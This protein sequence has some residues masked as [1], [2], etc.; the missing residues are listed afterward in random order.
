VG[1]VDHGGDRR[2][3]QDTPTARD[4][5]RN[6]VQIGVV[7]TDLDKTLQA[8]SEIVGIGPWRVVKCPPPGREDDQ[9]YYGERAVFRTRQAFADLGPI[10]LELIQPVE[11]RTIWSDFLQKHGQGIHHIRFNVADIGPVME[12]VRGSGIRVS[13]QG[14]GIRAGTTWANFDTQDLIGFTLEI[15]NVLPGTDGRTP[16]EE[17]TGPG[18]KGPRR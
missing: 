12:H 1:D 15:M 17:D 8:L 5:F 6:F 7:V 9:W 3:S 11:G 13:Q 18:M 2:E 10:E 16:R 14:A 4:L